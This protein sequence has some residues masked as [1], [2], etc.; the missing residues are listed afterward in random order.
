MINKLVVLNCE[1]RDDDHN[2]RRAKLG[3]RDLVITII[4]LINRGCRK[5]ERNIRRAN[6]GLWEDDHYI[7]L[8]KLDCRDDEH[9]ICE[10]NWDCM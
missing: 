2:I 4:V 3:Q 8:D 10:L 7:G 5:D 1:F 9:I 6:L